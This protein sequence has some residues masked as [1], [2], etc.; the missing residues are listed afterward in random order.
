MNSTLPQRK[1]RKHEKEL[2]MERVVDDRRKKKRYP[3][4]KMEDGL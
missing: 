2:K 1:Q 3:K 4:A